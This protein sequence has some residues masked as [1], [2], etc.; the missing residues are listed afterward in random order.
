MLVESGS[1][2]SRRDN[3]LPDTADLLMLRLARLLQSAY[4]FYYRE[5]P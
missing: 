2:N 4:N 1:T 3:L 5:G